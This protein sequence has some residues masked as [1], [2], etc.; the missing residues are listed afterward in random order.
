MPK[1]DTLCSKLSIIHRVLMG[2]RQIGD[3]LATSFVHATQNDAASIF[4]G[5]H[6][7]SSTKHAYYVPLSSTG[8]I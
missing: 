4:Q 7:E 2:A 5:T 1:L 3:T 8:P 6:E